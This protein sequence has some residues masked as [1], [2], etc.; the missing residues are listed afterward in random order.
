MPKCTTPNGCSWRACGRRLQRALPWPTIPKLSACSPS[1]TVVVGAHV[2]DVLHGEEF[3][4][5]ARMIVNTT[6]PWSQPF[7]RLLPRPLRLPPFGHAQAINLMTRSLEFPCAV[8]VQSWQDYPRCRYV[9]QQRQSLPLYH[10]LA[11]PV[12]DWHGLYAPCLRD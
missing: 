9:D 10:P 6:G 11:R 4:I 3:D 8:G 12:L 2:Q 5:R 7:L 1:R